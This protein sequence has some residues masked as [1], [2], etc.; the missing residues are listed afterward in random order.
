MKMTRI[1]T[2]SARDWA[3]VAVWYAFW[4]TICA[5]LFLLGEFLDS[6]TAA[7]PQAQRIAAGCLQCLQENFEAYNAEDV[8]AMMETLS[9]ALPGRQQFARES[10]RLFDSADPYISIRDFEVIAMQA[11][12]VAARVVQATHVDRSTVEATGFRQKSALLPVDEYTEYV[13]QFVWD[14]KEFKMWLTVTEPQQLT[15]QQ[16]QARSS[17]RGGNCQFPRVVLK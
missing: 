3:A 13:Q 17:C 1:T 4:L 11:P 12:Y 15:E 10:Q 5:V 8:D 2:T 6:V 16:V 14:G 7:E 9:P